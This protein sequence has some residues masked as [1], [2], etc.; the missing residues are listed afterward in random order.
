M[1]RSFRALAPIFAVL[2]LSGFQSQSTAEADLGRLVKSFLAA[3]QPPDWRALEAL[4]GTKWAPLPPTAPAN[5]LSNGDCFIRQG[6]ALI[7]G[8]NLVVVASGA[9]TMVFTLTMRKMGAPLGDAAVLA[10]L[11]QAGLAT[12]LARCPV[13]GA[14]TNWYRVTG[15]GVAQGFMS[16]HPAGTGRANE[17]YIVTAGDK[18]PALQPNQLAMYS[19][20]CDAGASRTA[21]ASVPPHEAIAALVITL[22]PG[23]GGAPLYDWKAL[24]ALPTGITWAASAPVAVDMRSLGDL[25][26]MQLNGTVTLSGR[27][28]HVMAT[29][30]ASQVKAVHL[31]E[32]MMHPTGE[33][34]L[35][36]VHARGV[37]VRLVR[38]GPVYTQSTNNWYSLTG[39]A[40]RPANI[41]QSI[42]YEGKI[43]QDTYELRLDNTLPARDPRDRNPG[44]GGC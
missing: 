27:E 8:S 3:S 26:P 6:T 2:L 41:R 1:L 38:C 15:M 37:P 31:T 20:R 39:S 34:M 43:V 12:A 16:V 14:G 28:F 40:T 19:D 22:L 36:V 11:K 24:Q 10:G 35:G 30:T 23:S 4:P 7:G 5:C 25:N 44:T 21:V 29:G 17:G 13:R 32:A 9:R 42:R 33:H 18:P